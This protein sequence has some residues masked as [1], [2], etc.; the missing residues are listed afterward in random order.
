MVYRV[1]PTRP[2]GTSRIM[3]CL[4]KVGKPCLDS[5]QAADSL[6]AEVDYTVQGKK[7]I[8]AKLLTTTV[9]ILCLSATALAC[10]SIG[11]MTRARDQARFRGEVRWVMQAIEERLAVYLGL[12]RG[13]AGLM[14]AG[15]EVNLEEFRK[16]VERLRLRESYPGIQ[17]IG[18][19]KRVSAADAAEWTSHIRASGQPG[20]T[21]RPPG[22]R[23]DYFPILYLEPMDNRNRE[24]IGYDMFSDPVRNEA[25]QRAR[26]AGRSAASG[27][28]TLVQEIDKNKQAGFLIYSPV[29]SARM[30]EAPTVAQRRENILGF[31]YS[32]F[33]AT[34]M[35][36]GIFGHQEPALHFEAYDGTELTPEAHMHSNPV[37]P[38]LHPRFSM[39]Q[40]L[41]V[42]GRPWTILFK[43]S[44][45]FE[46]GS[47]SSL[48][49]WVLFSGL[50][51]SCIVAGITF[52]LGQA[53][54][55][56][57]LYGR[58]LSEA[59]EELKQH[60]VNLEKKVLERTSRLRETIA[61]LE[62]FSYSLSHDMRA[63][64]RSIQSFSQFVVTDFGDRLPPEAHEYLARVVAAARRM[65]RLIY[66]VLSYTRLSRQEISMQ[67]VDIAKL[68]SA[69]EREQPELQQPNADLEVG[70]L[71]RVL[72]NDASLTQCI[73]NLM[74]NA[75][76]FVAPGVKPRIRVFGVREQGMVRIT[77]EDNGIGIEPK[78]LERVFGLFERPHTGARYEGTGLGLAIARK[79]VERM[80]GTIGVESVLGK[81]SRFWILLPGAP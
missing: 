42:E 56:A 47:S 32:P 71:P 54:T 38:S 21:I 22:T 15:G 2:G 41:S 69:I 16:F 51:M 72:G 63:P 45:A 62:A 1:K 6:C 23:A 48:V 25:M 29:Y 3:G 77:V 66:D 19:A 64:L 52:S 60:T 80:Q 24:A 28:V 57:E 31:I 4:R 58:Q 37:K 5:P 78:N 74:S 20:F 43:T 40:R 8:P 11:V 46:E 59:Q 10:I 79:A 61:E 14:A 68:V 13:G 36:H 39:V 50:I 49:I 67:P 17:G 73:A 27:K 26:D 65:D 9:F 76:K 7:A 75:A 30:P 70:P 18:Y 81:G 12:L 35:F 53:R 55:R 33:R 44:E 34:D